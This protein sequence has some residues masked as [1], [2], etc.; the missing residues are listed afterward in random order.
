M[1]ECEQKWKKNC[2]RN[3]FRG[4]KYAFKVL[5]SSF[6]KLEFSVN[7]GQVPAVP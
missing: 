6:Y 4:L 3:S 2:K 7:I 1:I 5:G